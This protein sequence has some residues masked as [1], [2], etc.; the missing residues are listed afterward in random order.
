MAKLESPLART[1]FFILLLMLLQPAHFAAAAGLA[2][3]DA[4]P[5]VGERARATYQQSFLTAPAHRAFAIAPGGAWAWSSGRASAAEARQTAV[6]ECQKHTALRCVAYAVDDNLVF[7]REQWA[8]LWGP[9]STPEQAAAAATG[10]DVG[11]CFPDVAFTDGDGKPRS[12][13]GLRGKVVMVHFWGSWCPPCLRELPTLDA[14]NR[15]LLDTAAEEVVLVLLQLREPISQAREWATQ[16]GF[17]DLPLADSGTRDAEDA[18]LL[19]STGE[20]IPD[21]AL[22]RVFPSSYVLDRNGV[23][24]FS[25]TGPVHDW[26]EYLPFFL[27]AAGQAPEK[28]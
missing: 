26:T 12:I 28:Q 20:Q 15:L 22:A 6:E 16:Q 10:T 2:D 5:H 13:A 18:F 8:T 9:Y 11:E 19:T 25:H 4:I 7:S 1:L 23:V 3:P 17:S 24:V 21:R 27:D 14:L